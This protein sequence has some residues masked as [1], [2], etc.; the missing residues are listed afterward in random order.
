[1]KNESACFIDCGGHVGETIHS[2]KQS[3][4]YESFDWRIHSFEPHHDLVCKMLCRDDADVTV[5]QKAVWTR[6]GKVSFFPTDGVGS[7]SGVDGVPWGSSTLM[8]EKTSGRVS[9]ARSFEVECIDLAGF[10]FEQ[11]VASSNIFLKLDI[12]GAEYDVI[13]HLLR[14]GAMKNV[15]HLFV[16]FHR[17]KMDGYFFKHYFT[18]LRLFPM[19]RQITVEGTNHISG[20]WF[21]E[22]DRKFGNALN[23]E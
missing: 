19:R 21:S 20:D 9:P 4:L 2:F 14:T 18:K 23:A 6:D 7:Y 11:A 5:H 8:A 3:K 22:Y 12:E 15:K 16:E 13:A 1:M 17:D 10:I